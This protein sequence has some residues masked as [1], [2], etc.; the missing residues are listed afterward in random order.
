MVPP[1]LTDIAIAMSEINMEADFSNFL[2]HLLLRDGVYSSDRDPPRFQ[3]TKARDRTELQRLLHTLSGRVDRYLECDRL[4][5]RDIESS[6]LNLESQ[7]DSA[8]N[9]RL[10]L[11][12]S[13]SFWHRI[14]SSPIGSES[15]I[16]HTA[17]MGHT[18]A[19]YLPGDGTE[20]K[21][22]ELRFLFR[23]RSYKRVEDN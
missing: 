16:G 13:P 7:D 18:Y 9:D 5:V 22:F 3:R 1:R 6:Y 17:R 19:R 2:A 20:A 21:G 10:G 8:M 12:V 15:F 14:P 4:L 11:S 23:K